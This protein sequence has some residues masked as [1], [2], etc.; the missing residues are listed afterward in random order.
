M[1]LLSVVIA[2]PLLLTYTLLNLNAAAAAAGGGGAF[3]EGMVCLS[4]LQ[5]A[6]VVAPLYFLR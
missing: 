3:E 5:E 2:N 4:L 1:L 6:R